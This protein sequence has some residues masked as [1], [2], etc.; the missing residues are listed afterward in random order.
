MA[1]SLA[2]T[3]DTT[4]HAARLTAIQDRPGVTQHF[5]EKIDKPGRKPSSSGGPIIEDI[6]CVTPATEVLCGISDAELGAFDAEATR[7]GLPHCRR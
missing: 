1:R 4:P 5:R 6:E 7:Q 3:Q 2:D